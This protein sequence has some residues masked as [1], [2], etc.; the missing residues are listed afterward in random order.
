M[1]AQ[2]H[3]SSLDQKGRYRKAI[4]TS[5][6]SGPYIAHMR[7]GPLIAWRAAVLV[8]LAVAVGFNA[9]ML[10]HNLNIH[11]YTAFLG[12]QLTQQ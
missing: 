10:R 7:Y 6:G 11:I 3:H 8:G 5:T 1:T 2:R 12:H 9:S 4:F